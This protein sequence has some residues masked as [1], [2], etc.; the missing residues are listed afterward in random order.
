MEAKVCKKCGEEKL[1]SSFVKNKHCKNGITNEC[2]TCANIRQND[3]IYKSRW[4]QLNKERTKEKRK[5]SSQKYNQSEKGK[6]KRM[7]YYSERKAIINKRAKEWHRANST[8]PKIRERSNL[9]H[10]IYYISLLNI[11]Y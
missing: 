1:F 7:K 6:I 3:P 2:M 10:H 5:E 8:N 4:F 11:G 9:L